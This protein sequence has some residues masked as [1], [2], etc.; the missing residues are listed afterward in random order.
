MGRLYRPAN[1]TEGALFF[2]KWCVRC[3]HDSDEQ[4][5]PILGAAY[6][7]DLEDDRYPNQW[8]VDDD[9]VSNPHCTTFWGR[10]DEDDDGE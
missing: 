9:G 7:Y 1:S 8:R 5:C 4:P 3:Q 6:I 10:D 2:G